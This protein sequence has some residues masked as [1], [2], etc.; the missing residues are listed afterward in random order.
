MDGYSHQGRPRVRGK[1]EL[2]KGEKKKREH[3]KMGGEKLPGR[4][5]KVG[6]R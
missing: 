5:E 4:K 6:V 2:E 3:F 1:K